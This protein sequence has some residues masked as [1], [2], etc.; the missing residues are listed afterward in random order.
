MS[1]HSKTMMGALKLCAVASLGLSGAAQMAS[2]GLIYAIDD[3]NNLFSFDNLSPQTI[4]SGVF[5]TG[6]QSNEHLVNIDFRPATGTLYGLGS[7]SQVYTINTTTGAATAVGAGLGGLSGNTFGMDFNPVVDAIRLVSDTETNQ[8]LNPITGSLSSTDTP[9][10]YVGGT[11]NPNI[12][13]IGYTNNVNPAPASTTLY[14]IDSNTNSLV[15]IG[16]LNGAPSPN[17]GVLTTVGPLGVDA[18]NFVGFDITGNN[19]AFAAIQPVADGT[20]NL[21]AVDLV[22]GAA[23]DQGKIL[24]GVRVVDIAVIPDI[25]YIIPEPA[26]LGLASFALLLGL[27]R[28]SA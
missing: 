20:S 27:R 3:Q 26:M 18:S 23:L 21:Y 8:R 4:S 19:I 24:G 28:R 5:V 7:S 6:L 25:E 2:A 10:A 1:R 16:G 15:L 11:P 14:G 13:G 9:L 22:T 17:G 12:T